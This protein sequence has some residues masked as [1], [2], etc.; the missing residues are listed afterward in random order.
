[1]NQTPQ[2]SPRSKDRL[3]ISLAVPITILLIAAPMVFFFSGPFHAVRNADAGFKR[4]K[5]TIN[6]EKL[7]AWA[8]QAAEKWPPTTNGFGFRNIPQSE[9]PEYLRTL[10]SY[11][12]SAIVFPGPDREGPVVVISWGGGFFHWGIDVGSTNFVRRPNSTYPKVFQ[13]VRGIDYTR[14]SSWNLQ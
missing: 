11:S 3:R 2:A 7:R 4:A 10:Y 6:P 5:Q 9:I 12:P 1:M 8:L 14:E 13:W